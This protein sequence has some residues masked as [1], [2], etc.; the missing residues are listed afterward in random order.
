MYSASRTGWLPLHGLASV[1]YFFRHSY[2]SCQCTHP[3]LISG[4][5]QIAG[6]TSS[7]TLFQGWMIEGKLFG[8]LVFHPSCV[9]V[10]ERQIADASC[11]PQITESV[12]HI[13]RGCPW[14][15]ALSPLIATNFHMR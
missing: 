5:S 10:P 7:D 11:Y 1:F 6:G 4:I 8:S 14:V 2:V 9:Y 3:R 12:L 15:R 13:L